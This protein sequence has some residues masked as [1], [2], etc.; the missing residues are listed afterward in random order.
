[1]DRLLAFDDFTGL[2]A[3]VASDGRAGRIDLRTGRFELTGKPLASASSSDGA[4]VYGISSEGR[5][6]RSTPSGEWNGPVAHADSVFTLPGGS[7]VLVS[8]GDRDTRLVRLRPP[9]TSPR[10]SVT[11]PV[12][13]A[14]ARTASGDRL[15]AHTSRGI[16]TIDTRAWRVVPGPRNARNTIAVAPTPSGDR[17]LVLGDKGREIRVWERYTD[18]FSGTLTLPAAARDLRMDPM[19][20]FMLARLDVGDSAYVISVP[21]MRVVRTVATE[22]RDDLPAV[23]P[24]GLILTLRGDDV[25]MIDPATGA[26]KRRTRGGALDVWMFVRWD[27]FKPRDSSLDTPATFETDA[28][29]DS[30]TEAEK[31]DS[32]LAARAEIVE[33]E[34]MDSV[35]RATSG[36][37]ARR[38][39]V[40]LS[41]TLSF[42]SLLSESAARTLASRIRVDGR[43]PRVVAGTRDG[44]TIYRVVLGPYPTREAAEA[45]GRRSGVTYWV[46]AGLP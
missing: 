46:F 45:A 36:G 24:D 15:Y 11:I 18:R 38:D 32:L 41:Y 34:R 19:G 20:R 23:A 27:G 26:R 10:D 22:W 9:A 1:V 30:V 5:L 7:V 2:L 8:N 37:R 13:D 35:A 42:A 28:P 39:T 21:L 6:W 16:V 25:N 40:G 31:I 33:R 43:P 29:M 4:S 44:L 12:S 17:A 3:L 14:L